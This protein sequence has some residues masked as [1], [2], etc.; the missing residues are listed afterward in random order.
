VGLRFRKGT[1]EHRLRAGRSHPSEELVSTI[2]GELEAA[3]SHRRRRLQPQLRLAG[4]SSAIA[5]GILAVG[6]LGYAM[7]YAGDFVTGVSHR[8][9][10]GTRTTVRTVVLNAANDQYGTTAETTTTAVTTTTTSP[11]TTTNSDGSK[12]TEVRGSSSGTV[13]V[14]PPTDT[15]QQTAVAWTPTTF[16]KPVVI[17]VDPTPPVAAPAF[18]GPASDRIVSI[19]VTDKTTGAVIHNLAAPLEIVFSNAPRGFVPAV[20]EDGV[21]FRALAEISGPPLP[22]NAQDGFYRSGDDIHIVTRHLTQFAVLYKAHLSTS[23]SG[24]KTQPAGSGKFGDPTRIH[25]G[26]PLVDVVSAPI[27]SGNNVALTFSVDEQVAVYVQVLSGST[28]LVLGNS[29]TFRKHRIGGKSR[30]TFHLVI[31]RPGSINLNLRVPGLVAGSKVHLRFVDY[32][33]KKVDKTVAVK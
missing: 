7:N 3:R 5:L 8:I 12:S 26:A 31:L 17:T 33:G 28:Q 13:T 27:A 24:R 30:K 32:D 23:E 22:D 6:G 15:T 2:K 29:S 1:L 21:D 10:V 20:S 19:V 9:V 16:D 4:V 25:I 14:A 18:L 11:A